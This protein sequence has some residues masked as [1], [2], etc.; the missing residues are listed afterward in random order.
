MKTFRFWSKASQQVKTPDRDWN[1]EC[2]GGSDT[3]VAE[4]L[5]R[6]EA[7]VRSVVAAVSAGRPPDRY[8]YGDRPLREEIVHEFKD[9]D[10]TVALLTRNSHGALVLNTASVLFAD[11]DYED[12]FS[13]Q[14]SSSNPNGL[15]GQFMRFISGL[16]GSDAPERPDNLVVEQRP[17][18][19]SQDQLII[20]GIREVTERHEGLGLRLYRTANGFR[21]LVTSGTWDPLAPETTRL[22]EEL[23]SDPLYVRLCRG[24][25]CFRARL[26]P[27]PWRCD[28][29]TAPSPFPWQDATAEQD[30]REWV[31]MYEQK[32]AHYST[33]AFIGE[34]GESRIDPAV[35][36]ILRLHDE[37]T[38]AGDGPI[39]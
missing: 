26:S 20:D 23:G 7:R 22:L 4:A 2:Y 32:T 17:T 38:C 36:P 34:F 19:V 5:Q 10:E 24:Q 35:A 14:Q 12:D 18:E 28:I 25:E 6:A 16:L 11:I 31:S 27:K 37:M 29:F 3:S 21:C 13:Q 33:C 9:Q 39:A 30:Y 8:A 15:F 1:I